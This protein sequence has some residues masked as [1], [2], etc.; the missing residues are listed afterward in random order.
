MGPLK[1]RRGWDSKSPFTV[2]FIGFMALNRLCVCLPQP[3]LSWLSQHNQPNPAKGRR[4]ENVNLRRSSAVTMRHH[5]RNETLTSSTNHSQRRLH[6]RMR[7]P[8][9][10]SIGFSW[11]N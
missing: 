11:T 2:F 5:V 1:W 4:K 10:H 3:L 9:Q 6:P 7:N 8:P